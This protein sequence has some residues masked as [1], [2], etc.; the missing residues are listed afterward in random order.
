MG[1]FP[2]QTSHLGYLHFRKT[3]QDHPGGSQ[4]VLRLDLGV[5][6]CETPTGMQFRSDTSQGSA[7]TASERNRLVVERSQVIV[8]KREAEE[9]QISLR[10]PAY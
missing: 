8:P 7:D 6:A 5:A 9:P 4:V 3:I 10:I 2:L 1:I